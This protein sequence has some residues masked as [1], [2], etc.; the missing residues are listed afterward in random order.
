MDAFNGRGLS[1]PLE[2]FGPW[3]LEVCFSVKPVVVVVS[4]L[5]SLDGQM[6]NEKEM[7]AGSNSASVRPKPMA[8]IRTE[9]TSI[10]KSSML[11]FI[12]ISECSGAGGEATCDLTRPTLRRVCGN[13]CTLHVN[14]AGRKEKNGP[15]RE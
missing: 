1:S 6:S 9:E 5:L 11:D 8:K 15:S 4:S 2:K 13:T 3:L 12:V 7:S 10:V 14:V